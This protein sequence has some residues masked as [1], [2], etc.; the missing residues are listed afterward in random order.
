MVAPH[1]HHAPAASSAIAAAISA[2][3]MLPCAPVLSAR[4]GRGMSY[5]RMARYL[6][7]HIRRSSSSE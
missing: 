5:L 4:S 7:G 6:R 2:S 3:F 1:E